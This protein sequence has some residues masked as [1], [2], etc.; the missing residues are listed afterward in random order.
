VTDLKRFSSLFEKEDFFQGIKCNEK[1]MCFYVQDA[2][3][4]GSV[5]SR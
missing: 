4:C 2:S 5:I 3:V 1:T